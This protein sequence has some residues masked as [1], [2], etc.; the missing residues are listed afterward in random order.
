VKYNLRLRMFLCLCLCHKCVSGFTTSVYQHVHGTTCRN[1]EMASHCFGASHPITTI[2]EKYGTNTD[3][4][5]FSNLFEIGSTI[6]IHYR[7]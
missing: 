6:V 3:L 4:P 1:I 7:A 2:T 5:Y